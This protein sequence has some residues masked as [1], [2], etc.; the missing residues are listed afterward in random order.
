MSGTAVSGETL[1][2]LRDLVGA[3]GEALAPALAR[4]P[5]EDVLA[6][7]VR[8]AGAGRDDP[9]EYALV[10][11][12]VLEGYLLHFGRPRLLDTDDADLRLL[13]GD[14][15]YALGLSRLARLGDLAAVRALADLITLSARHHAAGEPDSDLLAG[16]WVSS[17]L[18]VATG[19]DAEHRRVLAALR[20]GEVTGASLLDEAA[21]RGAAAG[22]A[23]QAQHALIAFPSVA[24]GEPHG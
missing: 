9:G 17:A 3:D 4:S 20:A 10:I 22:V 18:A 13:A 16:L 6:P 1:E 24:R 5:G 14:Y 2:R 7:L 15:M 8:S 19:P 21:R 12:S 11:E 23:V